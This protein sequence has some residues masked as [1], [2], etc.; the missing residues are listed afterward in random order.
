ML[1][2]LACPAPCLIAIPPTM[3]IG[4]AGVLVAVLTGVVVPDAVVRRRSS[5][6]A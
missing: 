5:R 6:P 4:V 3:L 1:T 2:G